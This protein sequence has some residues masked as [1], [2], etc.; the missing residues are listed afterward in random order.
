MLQN[1]MKKFLGTKQD[2]DIKEIQ[3]LV[4]QIN[5]LEDQM[6][7]MSDEELKAQTNKFRALLE[8]GSTINDIL[9]EAFATAREAS[10][11]VLGMRPYDVQIMGG[12]VL[13]EGKIA[14]MKTGE[15]KTLTAGLPMYLRALDG[16]GAHLVTVNDYLA[17]RDAKDMGELYN[18]LGLSVG[19]IVHN[20]SDE[21]RKEAYK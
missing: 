19:C 7:K 17:Q 5:S 16:K 2:R 4:Q 14:E 3:P 9:P 21:D 8:K 20:M 10:V 12:I 1:V 6:K 15:G 11:R 18:W 13:S